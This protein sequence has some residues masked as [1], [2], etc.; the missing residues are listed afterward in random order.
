[1]PPCFDGGWG[2]ESEEEEEQEECC[3]TA[4]E[5][6]EI[7]DGDG[8]DVDEEGVGCKAEELSVTEPPQQV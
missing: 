5:E 7:D 2:A 3:S 1:M 6:E 4:E 8:D